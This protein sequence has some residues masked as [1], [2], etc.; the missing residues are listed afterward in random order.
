MNLAL[1]KDLEENEAV[2]K[3]E[4]PVLRVL[5]K[6]NFTVLQKFEIQM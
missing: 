3:V 4:A 5:A 6:N 2:T 1:E